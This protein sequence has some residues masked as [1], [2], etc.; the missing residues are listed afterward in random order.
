MGGLGLSGLG[1]PPGNSA[2]WAEPGR[3]RIPLRIDSGVM[4]PTGSEEWMDRESS[5][6]TKDTEDPFKYFSM[7]SPT[8]KLP[9]NPTPSDMQSD[10]RLELE[11]LAV[12]WCCFPD[13]TGTYGLRPAM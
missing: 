1:A 13:D 6:G 9:G 4:A 7:V 10:A 11:V 12:R 3:G 2:F 8:A 5:D